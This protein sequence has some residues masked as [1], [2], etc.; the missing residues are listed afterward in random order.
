MDKNH[1]KQK[2]RLLILLIVLLLVASSAFIS[3]RYTTQNNSSNQTAQKADI[4]GLKTYENK[5]QGFSFE[6]PGCW[7]VKA[8]S[9]IEKE[10][11]GRFDFSHLL[12]NDST[13]SSSTESD[14]LLDVNNPGM[15]FENFSEA[16]EKS[17]QIEIKGIKANYSIDKD[18]ENNI[19]GIFVD[20]RRNDQRNSDGKNNYFMLYSFRSNLEK[21]KEILNRIIASF[22][23]E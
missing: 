14:L 3:Y 15:G 16:I 6:Y 5:E 18:P 2:F 23:F 7:Q 8:E 11:Y 19:F 4:S 9:Y 12:M 21:N 22:K 1:N 13:C 10:S 17:R 20:F